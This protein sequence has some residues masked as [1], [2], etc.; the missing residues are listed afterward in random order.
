MRRILAIET[1]TQGRSEELD[2][3]AADLLDKAIPQLLRPLETRGRSIRPALIHGDLQIRNVKT[4]KA[5]GRPTVFDAGSFSQGAR[6]SH[7]FGQYT[8]DAF[9]GARP[10]SCQAVAVRFADGSAWQML[11]LHHRL[12]TQACQYQRSWR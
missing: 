6:I 11:P 10:N 9:L 7:T 4:D 3:L 2:A 5:T 8:G 1:D 12:C